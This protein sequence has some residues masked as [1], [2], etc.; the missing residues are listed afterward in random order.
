MFDRYKI[1][2]ALK[3]DINFEDSTF[4]MELVE[5]SFK[6]SKE[7]FPQQSADQLKNLIGDL[8][9]LE[10]MKRLEKTKDGE[11]MA[12]IHLLQENNSKNCLTILDIVPIGGLVMN[13]L[14]R[15]ALIFSLC[16]IGNL[17]KIAENMFYKRRVFFS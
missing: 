14:V 5:E 6:C 13:H 7:R 17:F 16:Q 4:N 11:K 1:C 10:E 9:Y 2:D 3:L 8:K 15:Y 12:R